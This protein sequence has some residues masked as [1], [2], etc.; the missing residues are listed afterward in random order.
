M[1]SKLAEQWNNR[2]KREKVLVFVCLG[3][4]L[5]AVLMQPPSEETFQN[6]AADS[7]ILDEPGTS[8][9][10]LPNLSFEAA[11]LD[12]ASRAEF[13]RSLDFEKL[14]S[15]S[16]A[17]KNLSQKFFDPTKGIFKN[18]IQS[19]GRRYQIEWI[20]EVDEQARKI[21]LNIISIQ[22][23]E[24]SLLP[25][26]DFLANSGLKLKLVQYDRNANKRIVLEY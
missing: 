24:A 21:T 13:L 4:I 9:S 22:G 19:L 6:Q 1:S 25:A 11:G 15:Q 14:K 7:E 10:W 26:L 12:L 16:K 5:L 3:V 17:Y 2:S 23:T 20:P 8:E 18:R